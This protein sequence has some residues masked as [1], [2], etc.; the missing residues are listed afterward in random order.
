MQF[1]KTIY[2]FLIGL[3][4]VAILLMISMFFVS[5]LRAQAAVAPSPS[6]INDLVPGSHSP[7]FFVFIGWYVFSA[8]VSGMPEPTHDSSPWYIWAYRSF[9]I[10]SASGT[11]FFQNKIY[12]PTGT[13]PKDKTM[14]KGDE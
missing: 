6:P 1:K 3:P 2:T 14:V 9:H 4:F 12:W 7:W 13:L 8:L 10:L 5:I 11:S